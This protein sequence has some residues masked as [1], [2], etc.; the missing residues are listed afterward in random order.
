MKMRNKMLTALLCGTLLMTAAGSGAV[1]A[2]GNAFG[3]DEINW[4]D[5]DWESIAMTNDDTVETGAV[6]R[7]QA[8]TESPAAGY[9][10][11]GTAVKVVNKGE[12]WTEVVSGKVSG[13]VRNEYLAFGDAAR[14]LAAHYG[15]QGV[16]ANWNEVS[17][18]NAADG[19]SSVSGTADSGALFGLVEDN[20][21]WITVQKGKEEAGY[22]SE[23]DV[24][25]VLLVDTAVPAEG[26]DYADVL[27]DMT[28]APAPADA[29]YA[30]APAE[31]QESAEASYAE[32]SYTEGSYTEESYT[33]DSYTES[34]Y[35]DASGQ[36][37]ASGQEAASG[38]ETYEKTTVSDDPA[39]QALYDA[40]IDAQNAAMNCTSAEDAQT[41]A[42]AATAAWNAYLAACN[43]TSAAPAAAAAT[44]SSADQTQTAAPA[45][46]ASADQSTYTDTSAADTSAQTGTASSEETSSA[47]TDNSA[48]TAAATNINSGSY[49]GYSDLDLLAAIIWCEAG[50]QPYDGMVAV[51]QVVMNRVHSSSFPN[52]VAEVLNQPGQF[53]PAS[54]GVLQS[55]LAAGIN[56]S[57]YSAAQDAL[58]GAT[59]VAG[60]P[61]YFNTH[62]G[63]VKL[64][65][66]YFS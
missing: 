34:A 53:T 27:T 7:T 30:E 45:D 22:V 23:E 24:T 28:A 60:Y 12:E 13:F 57:C 26:E 50:N 48:V 46:T 61:L 37:G 38:S 56:S 5:E 65:A 14:G 42:D 44:A 49:A 1:F 10:Y 41:K 47:Q 66:H 11:R 54:S 58:N 17:I 19:E 59:P 35:E 25:R 8:D 63:S 39:I 15:K 20:G 6:I 32:A 64:G 43:G 29:S 18:Y 31:V 52:T 9:L 62:S 3:I 36:S 21:H 51:G 2:A 40:Y 16:A 33:D 4:T 55:A